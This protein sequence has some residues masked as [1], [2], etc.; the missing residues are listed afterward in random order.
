MVHMLVGDEDVVNIPPVQEGLFQLPEDLISAAAVHQEEA[1]VFLQGKASIII[2][3]GQRKAGP[4]YVHFH[5]N[6]LS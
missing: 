2:F 6:I 5:E 1:A 3:C 4:Q